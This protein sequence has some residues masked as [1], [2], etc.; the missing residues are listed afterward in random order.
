MRR[1]LLALSIA[2]VAVA[3]PRI[4]VTFSTE[5]RAEPVDGRLI[6]IVSKRLNGQPRFQVSWNL[7][8]QQIFGID[9]DGWKPGEG[10]SLTGDAIG[11]PLPSLRDLEPGAYNVQAVLHVYETIHRAGGHVLKLPMDNGEGQHWNRSPGNLFSEPAEVEIDD[12]AT[13]AIEMTKVI[14]PI[15]PAEDTK[16]IRRVRLESKL[17]S[18]FWGRPIEVGAIVLLPEGFDDNPDARYPV[19][20]KQGH[21]PSGFRNFREQQPPPD[22]K[23][24]ARRRWQA[25]HR[26]YQAW[27][28][29]RLPKMLIVLTQHAT[30]FY[31]DSY[32]VNSANMGP[33]GD[34][35][36]QELYPHVEERFRA[37]GKP[38]ARILYGGSTGGWISLAQQI[39]YPN[40]FGGAW[41]FCP[42]PVDFHA[43]QLIDVYKDEN[44]FH[45]AGP[46]KQ[47]AKPLA[48]RRSGH[49]FTTVDDFTR[50]E[51]VLGE[52]AR[53]G[54]QLDAFHAVFGPTGPDGYPV[55]LWDPRTGA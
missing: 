50:Q 39:F 21:F 23:G 31:D 20:F 51:L 43:F 38:W 42:D 2:S 25:G 12:D 15:K 28:S 1:L 36:T 7:S 53:S 30:P 29:G 3:A 17:L 55:K 8:T 24:S 32:G 44:A 27:T 54:G 45:D 11:H 4:E 16:Y 37:I 52:Q 40:Y 34:A 6:V 35:L 14:P 13:I 46:F 22:V 9:V 41:S 48:R 18:E 49:I 5:A 10:F 47:I 26:F 33:Y 19:L